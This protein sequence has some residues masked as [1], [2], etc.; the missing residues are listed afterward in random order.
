MTKRILGA[1][2]V[3]GLFLAVSCVSSERSLRQFN[4]KM[5]GENKVRTEDALG[6]P[7][8]EI[9]QRPISSSPDVRFTVMADMVKRD[10]FIQRYEKTEKFEQVQSGEGLM[11]TGGIM[12]GVGLMEWMFGA[13]FGIDDPNVTYDDLTAAE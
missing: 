6:E 2:M 1:A 11:V 7:R 10:S 3:M 4:E 9:V 8:I 5:V 13:M 12:S